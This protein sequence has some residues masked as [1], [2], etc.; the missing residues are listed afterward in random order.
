MDIVCLLAQLLKDFDDHLDIGRR[1]WRNVLC[2]I[3]CCL[4]ASAR[5]EQTTSII[6]SLSITMHII[7]MF[8]YYLQYKQMFLTK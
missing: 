6:S 2:L 4:V 8:F 5:T 3:E 1:K 7:I